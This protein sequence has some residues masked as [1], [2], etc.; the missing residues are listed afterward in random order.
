M[1][2]YDAHVIHQG[3]NGPINVYPE[4]VWMGNIVVLHQYNQTVKVDYRNI[5]D[6]IEALEKLID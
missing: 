6:L 2:R 4:K 5:K 1:A 3:N